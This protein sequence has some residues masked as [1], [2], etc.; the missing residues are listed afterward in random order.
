[1]VETIPEGYD[2]C[3]ACQRVLPLTDFKRE[4]RKAPCCILNC[5]GC[6]N[7]CGDRKR[8]EISSQRY[9]GYRDLVI[10][11]YGTVCQCC[12]VRDQPTI[13]HVD[14][15]GKAHRETITSF[16]RWL[17]DNGFPEGFQTLC[18]PCN[19]SKRAGDRCQLDHSVPGQPRKLTRTERRLMARS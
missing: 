12:G 11:H 7:A 14:G 2:W 8:R 10:A 13:D 5:W 17:V 15:D 6:R 19:C 18:R 4:R 1:M 9:A 3:P 16:Y